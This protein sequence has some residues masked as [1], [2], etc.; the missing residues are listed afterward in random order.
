MSRE[1]AEFVREGYEALARG[2]TETFTTGGA[3]SREG[4]FAGRTRPER[5]R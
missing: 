5:G 2:D 3:L 1:D 4:R